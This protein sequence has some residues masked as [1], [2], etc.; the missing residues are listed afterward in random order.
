MCLRFLIRSYFIVASFLL[1]GSVLHSQELRI[2]YLGIEDGLSNNAVTSIYQDHN[3]FMWFGTYDGLNRY[4]GYG[5]KVFRNV[6]G[7]SSSLSSN[8]INALDEDALHRLW[9]C[10]QKE[11]NIYNPVTAKFIKPSYTFANGSTSSSL[12]DNVVSVKTIS[13]TKVLVGTQHNG[14]FCFENAFNGKQVPL[15]LNGESDVKYYVDAIDFDKTKNIAYVFIAEHGLFTYDLQKNILHLETDSIKDANC[16][17]VTSTG[18]LWLGT[19][20]GLYLYDEKNHSFSKSFMPKSSRPV[21]SLYEDKKGILWIA[22]D[23]TGVW[24]LEQD[25]KIAEP[26]SPS[27]ENSK[28][29]IN[30]NAIYAIFE[31]K[32][33]RKWVG[34]LRGGVNIVESKSSL[35]KKIVYQPG[36][37][38]PVKNFIL[39]FCEDAKDQIWIGT[40]GA[41][42]RYWDKTNNTYQNFLHDEKN[43][44]SISSNFIT[45]IIKDADNNIWLS[46]WF[47]GI[48]RYNRTT[49]SFQHFRC[50]NSRI[51]TENTNVWQLLQDSKHRLWATAVR[52]G[53]LFQYNSKT[54]KFEEFDNRDKL[55]ELQC[56]AEDKNG[57]IW[58]GDYSSLFLIDTIYKNHRSFNIG[59][60]VRC[61]YEDSKR[62]FWVGTQEGGLL[63]F[64]RANGSYKRYTTVDGL[65]SNTILRV[66]E[67]KNGSLWLST[68]N[69]LCKFNPG[70]KAFRNFSQSDGLQSNQ[71]SYNAALRLSSGE[72]LFGGIGGFNI[73][74]PDSI[75]TKRQTPQILLAGL[76][77]NNT[78]I[79]DHEAY[80]K[81]RNLEQVKRIVV[82]YDQAMLSLDFLALDYSNAPDIKY[83]YYLKGWDK[84][85]NYVNKIRGANYSRLQEGDYVFEVRVS[86]AEGVWGEPQQ[87]LYI[88]VLP[89]WYR[90]WWAYALYVLVFG[91]AVY[92]YILYRD[93]QARLQY[94]VQLANLE[95]QKEK[96][97]N[98]KKI[99][100]FTN[101]S[102]EFR[103]PLSLIINPIKDLLQKAEEKKDTGELKIVY[104]NAKRLLRL[105]DQLLLFKKA[106]EETD[107]LNIVRVNLYD[108]CQDVFLCFTE[109]ARSKKIKYE[110]QS[111]VHDLIISADREKIEIAVF[112]IL[113]NAFKY[114]PD[115]GSIIFR[116]EEQDK[117]VKLSISDTG[118]GIPES[119]SSKLFERFAQVKGAQSKTGFGIG[120]YL[121]K[122][123]VEAHRGK[124]YFNSKEGEGTTFFIL[125]N[126]IDVEQK[127]PSVIQSINEVSKSVTDKDE[128]QQTGTSSILNEITEEIV[129]DDAREEEPILVSDQLATDKQALL[130]IDDD[131]EIRHYLV[132]LFSTEYKIHQADNG[133][134][135][136][137]IA[138]EQLPDLILSDIVMKD[139][140]GLDLCQTLKQ[141]SSLSHIP[142]ILL[143]G[144]SS[145]ETQLKAM[146]V[147]ADDYIK[148]PFDKDILIARV[149]SVLKRRNILQNYFYNE[150]TLGSGKFKVSPEYKDFI[151]K[152]MKIIEDHL[153]DDDFSIKVLATE[154]G[155]SHSNLYKKIK[156]VSG[157]SVNSFIRFIRL[158]KAAELF[159]N[160]EMNVNE[161]A[162]TVGFYHIKYFRSQFSKL[163][164]MNPSDYIKK[165]RKPFHNNQ[166]LDEKV[167]K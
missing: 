157:Q 58:G 70:D 20:T 18:K 118:P 6:I 153:Q 65:P 48:N 36:D 155:M 115:G 134:D 63:L 33:Q 132:S 67:D 72:F 120:L 144:S 42:L 95:T 135:G 165:F 69:G 93:K 21:V 28:P 80:V 81:E 117:Q 89:P 101:V 30:S 122:N 97:L 127:I 154:I 92:I 47:G 75:Q 159:I 82:P 141:D 57:N 77:V 31:D 16:L 166:T 51:K 76:T 22:S 107:K 104:R 1:V 17:R 164:G 12:K 78:S 29:L 27:A 130:I 102:H 99:A 49:K 156:A 167:R 35:F 128:I 15:R 149:K 145:D 91:S 3:G 4:D 131:N 142:I 60:T 123:F 5:F 54:N 73:F 86:I 152:C 2:R 146:N 9:V 138:K 119:E 66:L 125:L 137:R 143:T 83:A 38:N 71:F 25:K 98:E 110:L 158:K 105:V 39:S 109:Q 41:G 126:K 136:V 161:T 37:N 59:Y 116:I 139:V 147:G 129:E 84:H 19:N 14:L 32:D 108:L 40:D 53:G 11:V 114:T 106:E 88:T 44:S 96:E 55:S 46:T 68:Y 79:E 62:N 148:K 43:L 13:G 23:G 61:I 50:Y 52:N 87:L 7:D 133:K 34:T 160:T 10:G 8:G 24:L 111:D 103:T 140:D 94:Q 74:Y 85:W 113:S 45:S 90:T 150:I 151:E 64:N 56:I 121:V 124:V 100:F 163:F 112:N 26:F 162:N